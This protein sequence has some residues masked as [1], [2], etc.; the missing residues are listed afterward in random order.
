M[1][2]KSNITTLSVARDRAQSKALNKSMTVY[3]NEHLRAPILENM[4]T[5]KALLL[6]DFLTH[7]TLHKL[8]EQTYFRVP[9]SQITS[10][11]RF[12]QLTL[13]DISKY[14]IQLGNVKLHFTHPN[15]Q[16]FLDGPLLTLV[17]ILPSECESFPEV[18]FEYG[19]AYVDIARH[20]KFFS[21]VDKVVLHK[22][23]S[24]YSIALYQYILTYTAQPNITHMEFSLEELRLQMGVPTDKLKQPYNFIN[25]CLKSS[26]LDV[27]KHSNINCIYKKTTR[28]RKITKITLHWHISK[29]RDLKP[30][31]KTIIQ[32]K[33][34]R[35]R[36]DFLVHMDANESQNGIDNVAKFSVITDA[37]INYDPYTSF[38]LDLSSDRVCVWKSLLKHHYPSISFNQTHPLFLDFLK[39]QNLS[40]NSND[41]KSIFISF[42]YK[43]HNKFPDEIPINES[44]IETISDEIDF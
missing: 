41:L 23:K 13:A 33:L 39:Q 20:S 16:Y 9:L 40:P 43:L 36:D 28:G 19:T 17:G 2:D 31:Q 30:V 7:L 11:P 37:Q 4:P 18:V 21:L 15:E 34:E 44:L 1:T 10:H 32:N 26:I 25:R 12:H 35:N 22:L 42:L 14:I 29:S 6:F 27:N 8:P 3:A 24:K 5:K 38:P